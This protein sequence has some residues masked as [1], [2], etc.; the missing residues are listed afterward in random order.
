MSLVGT[1][2]DHLEGLLKTANQHIES[3]NGRILDSEG[4]LVKAEANAVTLTQ[5]SDETLAGL[6]HTNQQM[7]SISGDLS[8]AQKQI[9]TSSGEIAR[10]HQRLDQADARVAQTSQRLQGTVTDLVVTKDRIGVLE[11]NLQAANAISTPSAVIT[12]PELNAVKPEVGI[13]LTAQPESV[14]AAPLNDTQSRLDRIAALLAAADCQI[15]ANAGAIAEAA[16]RVSG[17]EKGLEV[18]DQRTRENEDTLKQTQQNLTG[19]E[20]QLNNAKTLIQVNGESLASADKRIVTLENHLTEASNRLDSGDKALAESKQ[21]IAQA[22]E[23]LLLQNERMKQMVVE[24]SKISSLAQEGLERAQAANKLAEGKLVFETMLSEEVANFGFEK[25]QLTE[26]A[27]SALAEIALRLKTEN[28]NVYIEIQGHTDNSGSTAVNL[29]LSQQR[30]ERVRDYLH[31]EAG[32]PLHRLS[33]VAYGEAKPVAD[34]KTKQGRKA[35]RRVLLVVL[36]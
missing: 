10:A 5:R 11:S 26:L 12:P 21:R 35:N 33:V 22:E 3:N 28:Q 25:A 34:N 1:R 36:K 27:R 14:A 16:T 2:I 29:K 6:A 8:A 32:I 18:T 24:E 15:A 23:N 7:N 19:V 20:Q 30:A 13:S 31:F 9:E 4:R 17:L